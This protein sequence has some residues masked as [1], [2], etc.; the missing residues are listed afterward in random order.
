[1]GKTANSKLFQFSASLSPILGITENATVADF[2]K[3][4]MHLTTGFLSD[5]HGAEIHKYYEECDW[6]KKWAEGLQKI[7]T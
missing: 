7:L 4:S 3:K 2:M 1:M 6:S 5:Y